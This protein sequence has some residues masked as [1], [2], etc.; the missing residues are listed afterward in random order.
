MLRVISF[1]VVAF[2]VVILVEFAVGVKPTVET[3]TL[4]VISVLI[5]L[6]GIM[7]VKLIVVLEDI[8]VLCVAEISLL[9]L[10][11]AGL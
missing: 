7:T 4:E 9:V 3:S 10:M 1:A 6:V 2:G 11:L 8:S 5:A